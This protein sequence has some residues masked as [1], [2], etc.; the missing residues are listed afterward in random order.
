MTT[1]RRRTVLLVALAMLLVAGAIVGGT[2]MNRVTTDTYAPS[3]TPA[4]AAHPATTTLPAAHQAFLDSLVGE[5]PAEVTANPGR[6][7]RRV[8]DTCAD[9]AAAKSEPIVAENARK[10]FGFESLGE[11][12][13]LLN[14]MQKT[15]ICKTF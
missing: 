14:I 10:R 15:E 12:L 13:R 7:M 5:L 11:A 2:L 9:I 4:A 1:P 3:T 8:E 6:T